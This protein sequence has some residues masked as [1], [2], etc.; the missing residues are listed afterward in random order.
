MAV[1]STIARATLLEVV[2]GRTMWVAGG[3]MLAALAMAAFL[4]Q[5]ALTERAEIQATLVA[6]TLRIGTAFLVA[7]AVIAGMAREANDKVIDLLL[8]QAMRRSAYFAGKLCGYALAAIAIEALAALPL[9]LFVPAARAWLWGGGLACEL[10]IVAAMAMFSALTFT[11]FLPAF[12]ATAA[13]YVLARSMDALR[14]IAESPF[15]EPAGWHDVLVRW[16]LD[17]IAVVMPPLDRLAPTSWLVDSAPPWIDF[18]G[19]V[20]QTTVYIALIAAASLFDLYRR[21]L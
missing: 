5:V 20:A 11:Q 19:L 1:V 21:N 17:G 12:A 10:L 4:Q 2:R 8:A 18:V 6:A 9:C 7:A 16:M 13:F 3:L 14:G 15:A